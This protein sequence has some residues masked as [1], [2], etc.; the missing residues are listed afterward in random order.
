[1]N[2]NNIRIL[3]VWYEP[4]II[5]PNSTIHSLTH[6]ICSNIVEHFSIARS[7]AKV[8]G[9]TM[10]KTKSSR[11][12]QS[13]GKLLLSKLRHRAIMTY[14]MSRKSKVLGNVGLE[15]ERAGDH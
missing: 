11:S 8:L 2:L 1:M 13:N 10:I 7:G 6:L 14:P 3:Y 9:L 15:L 4:S 5:S 12:S